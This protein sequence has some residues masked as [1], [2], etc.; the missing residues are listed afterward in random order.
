MMILETNALEPHRTGL[1]LPSFVG[2]TSNCAPK[3]QGII[4]FTN[5]SRQETEQG[6]SD[7]ISKLHSNSNSRYSVKSINKTMSTTCNPH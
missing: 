2:L 7:D 5:D 6:I 1:T 4:T 3:V